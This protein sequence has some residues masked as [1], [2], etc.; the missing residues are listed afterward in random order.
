[1][2]WIESL[3]EKLTQYTN[4]EFEY[5]ETSDI[6][7]AEKID[8]GATGI[9][10]EATVIYFE[11]KNIPFMLKENGRRKT[12]LAYTMY[13]EVL[14]TIADKSGAFVNCFAPNAFLVVYPGREDSSPEA[15]KGAMKIVYALSETYK[16]Q[17]STI[18]GL[19]FS[20]GLCHGHIMGSKNPSDCGY[21]NMTWF[22]TCI[23][24]AIRI[25]KECGR[26]F[27]IGIPSSLYH[28]LDEEL[29]RT[30]R[31]ILGIKKPV[32]IWNK[33]SY[34][35]ENVKKHL[36]QTNHKIPIEDEA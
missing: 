20:M 29:K 1:M 30:T 22:G 32:E 5:I 27:Y 35:Y 14:K 15:V 8:Y 24:K 23:Y 16:K 9:Y 6:K 12:A 10:M 34:Q 2:S 17:F 33:I 19:E 36:Y 25:S 18:N 7:E 21:E 11:I 31:R 4:T 28:T 26:P 13:R 3:D